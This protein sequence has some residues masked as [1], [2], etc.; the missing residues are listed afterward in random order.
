ME[1]ILEP[2]YGEQQEQHATL[3]QQSSHCETT[4]ST[5]VQFEGIRDKGECSLLLTSLKD[6][7]ESCQV[8][9]AILDPNPVPIATRRS[10]CSSISLIDDDGI[11]SLLYPFLRD[12]ESNKNAGQIEEMTPHDHQKKR[13]LPTFQ[14]CDEIDRPRIDVKKPKSDLNAYKTELY[15]LNMEECINRSSCTSSQSQTKTGRW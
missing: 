10:F 8:Q 14:H 7:D 1:N 6:Y 9:G 15:D 12:N 13:K 2:G 4:T 5:Y 3:P 11:Q